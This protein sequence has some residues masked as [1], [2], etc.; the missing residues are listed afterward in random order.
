MEDQKAE[1]LRIGPWVA[2]DVYWGPATLPARE[3]ASGNTVSNGA[4][5][6]HAPNR[7]VRTV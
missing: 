4:M 3:G 1:T 6:E 2:V 5:E 7:F